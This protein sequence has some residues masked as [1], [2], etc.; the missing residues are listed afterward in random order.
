[1][2]DTLS[3][4]ACVSLLL[5]VFLVLP[6]FTVVGE[7]PQVVSLPPVLG[8]IGVCPWTLAP[9]P[10]VPTPGPGYDDIS[11][12]FVGSVAVGIFLVES[13]GG[14][15]YW[16]DDEVA[17]TLEGILAALSWWASMEP[18][19]NISFAYELHIREPTSWEPIE[20]PLADSHLWISE[21]M[22]N[23][24]FPGSDARARVL[25]YNNDLR[26]RLGTDWAYSIFVADSDDSVN[27]GRFTDDQYACSYIG[28]PSFTMSRYSSW[29]YNSADYF[30]AVPAHETG[31]IFYA[32][33]EYDDDP[34]DFSGYLNCPDNNGAP[35]IMN[36]NTLTVSES[37]RCQLGWVD[38]DGDGI[39]DVLDTPPETTLD[40]YALDD[41]DGSRLR[42]AGSAAVVAR[43]NLNPRGPGNDVTICWI[44]GV[45]FRVDN[46]P[47]IPA[48]ADDGAFGGPIESFSFVTPPLE[49]GMHTIEVQARD[50]EGQVDSTPARATPGLDGVNPLQDYRWVLETVLIA[51][52]VVISL[53]A[54]VRHRRSVRPAM[55]LSD[56]TL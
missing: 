41:T 42:Y 19:A 34:L 44:A 21:I 20:N 8:E 22:A 14:A 48:K 30:L 26:G 40:S 50:S 47:W 9:G 10:R 2:A 45:D 3:A 6:T 36:R 56:D 52:V 12:F 33:D 15:Y 29:A 17:Q 37:T 16:S 18:S 32:T 35:G 5:L 28:G 24:G 31:H 54:L 39:L 53:L 49:T 11:E 55:R 4:R 38:S 1:M 27:Y 23:L 43:P 51:A 13:T 7:S 46:G 25:R